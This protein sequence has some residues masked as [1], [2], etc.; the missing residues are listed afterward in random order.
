MLKMKSKNGFQGM[1]L[2]MGILI[3]LPVLCTSCSGVS[4]PPADNNDIP[5]AGAQKILLIGSSYMSANNFANVFQQ[6]CEKFGQ[7]VYI[8]T[9]IIDGTYLDNHCDN[10]TTEKKIKQLKWD[11][12]VLQDTGIGTGYPDTGDSIFPNYTNHDVRRAL[13][14][15]KAKISANWAQS[16]MV[17]SMPWAFEDGTT[18]IEGETDTFDDMQGKIIANTTRWAK[19]I[20]FWLAPVGSAWQTVI[21][22]NHQ[23]HYLFVSD[24]NH[25]SMRGTYLYA[26]VVA[27]SIWRK[28]LNQVAYI[29]TLSQEEAFYFQRIASDI[30]LNNLDLWN[31]PARGSD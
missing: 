22:E 31:I 23:L 20:N 24:Y 21:H 29:S 6:L 3:V 11:A 9:D 30:V 26:C 12:V 5:D 8:G 25:P 14:V 18:W 2:V 28:P 13:A 17:F 10:A 19:E 15:L 27:A 7:H 1:F 16:I 4:T